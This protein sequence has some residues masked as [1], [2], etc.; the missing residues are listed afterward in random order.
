MLHPLDSVNYLKIDSE[1]FIL[2][3]CAEEEEKHITI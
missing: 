1:N 3:E 2:Y